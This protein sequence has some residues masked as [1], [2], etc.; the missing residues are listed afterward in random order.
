MRKRRL[1]NIIL[2]TMLS[3][4][5]FSQSQMDVLYQAGICDEDGYCIPSLQGFPRAK[6]LSLNYTTIRNQNIDTEYESE[7][8]S[9]RV[10]EI[11]IIQT[12]RKLNYKII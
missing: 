3:Q 10:K 5:I 2:L 4:W 8:F 6:G 7:K 12:S 9:G 1:H 11:S